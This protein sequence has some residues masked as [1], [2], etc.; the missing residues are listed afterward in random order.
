MHLKAGSKDSGARFKKGKRKKIFGIPGNNTF[1]PY[2]EGYSEANER[3]IRWAH[4]PNV[5]T[6][7]WKL[8]SYHQ[9]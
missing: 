8:A 6:G 1:L 3:A 7:D 9:R 5:K 4:N 2:D